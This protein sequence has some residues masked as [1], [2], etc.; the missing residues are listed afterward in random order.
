MCM[1][2]LNL[3]QEVRC[4]IAKVEEKT[5]LT[6]K[7]CH[8][9]SDLC[10][11]RF[12]ARCIVERPKDI[13]VKM[14]LE[15]LPTQLDLETCIA[16]E[17]THGLLARS[18]KY[19]HPISVVR[20]K[21]MAKKAEMI[22]NILEDIVIYKIVEQEGF[23][24]TCPIEVE[25]INGLAEAIE[26]SSIEDPVTYDAML[27]DKVSQSIIR[28][29][30]YIDCTHAADEISLEEGSKKIFERYLTAYRKRHF[31]E[32][33]FHITAFEDAISKYY[34]SKPEGFRSAVED[35]TKH[36]KLQHILWKELYPPGPPSLLSLFKN[37]VTR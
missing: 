37:L 22:G 17:I 12:R 26:Q 30:I 3:S 9:D 15:N 1:P 31:D 8:E 23:L 4:Y 32:D 6:I 29:G 25:H 11:R 20:D 16:H 21:I 35:L 36:F 7:F 5:E 2:L 14:C 19:V 27:K 34:I 10:K 24:S 13:L 33:K 18:E 28:V